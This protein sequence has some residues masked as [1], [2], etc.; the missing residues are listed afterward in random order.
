MFGLL[1]KKKENIEKAATSLAS[2]ESD[3]LI[4]AISKEMALIQFKPDGTILEANSQ[5]LSTMGYDLTTIV[6]KHHSIFCTSE[7][8]SSDKYKTFWKNLASGKAEKDQFI[9]VTQSGKEIWLDASYCPV[10]NDQNEVIKVIKVASDITDIVNSTHELKSQHNA[11]S[12][13]QAIIEFDLE[14]N[15]LTANENFLSTMG[16]Q[17]DDII[18]QHHSKFCPDTVTKSNEYKNFW[19]RLRNG[20]FIS[21]KFQRSA[22]DGH[23]VWLRASYNPIFDPMGRQYKVIKFATDISEGEIKALETD[24]L[25]ML[26]SQETEHAAQSGMQVGEEAISVMKDVVSG[27]EISSESIRSLNEQSDR[28]TNIVSTISAIADQTNLLAL[29]AAIEA[30]RAGEQGRGFAVVADEVRQLAARTSNS[31]SEIDE[32]V[33]RNHEM[34]STAMSTIEN[35]MKQSLKGEELIQETGQTIQ[36]INESTTSLMKALRG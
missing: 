5:F 33:K 3:Q 20:E 11:L 25:S 31:T 1:S 26:A 24:R 15:V 9:R 30:A 6:G 34:A 18:G 29:N 27:L 2:N 17:L 14:G 21:G 36:K 7:T 8:K 23:D 32:V 16:Y 4:A 22:S 35:V 12:R 10:L 28:I 13:S 19:S